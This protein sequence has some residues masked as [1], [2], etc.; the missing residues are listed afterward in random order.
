VKESPYDDYGHVHQVRIAACNG[1][2]YQKWNPC[3]FLKT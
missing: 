1:T 2:I 3:R